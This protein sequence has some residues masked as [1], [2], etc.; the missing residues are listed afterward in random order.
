MKDDLN[1]QFLKPA[2]ENILVRNPERGGHLAVEG[3]QVPRNSYWYRRLA[4][5]DVVT[6]KPT[7]EKK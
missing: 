2:N 6:A 3:E 7:K 5:G 4:D 1:T